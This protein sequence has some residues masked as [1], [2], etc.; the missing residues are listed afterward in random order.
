M[1]KK[2]N[3]KK[4]VNLRQEEQKIDKE[5][6]KSGFTHSKIV[7]II[8]AVIGILLVLFNLAGIL[9][10]IVGIVLIYFGLKMLGFNVKL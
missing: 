3:T 9:M 7:G 1:A 8:I 4:S 6:K 2:K 5:L 10:A